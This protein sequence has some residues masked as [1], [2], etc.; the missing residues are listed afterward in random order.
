MKVVLLIAGIGHRLG[1]KTKTIPKSLLEINNKPILFHIVDRIVDNG[2]KDFVVV[3]GYKKEKIINA[4][5]KKY[6]HLNFQFVINEIYDKTNTMYSLSLTKKYINNGII[7]AHG[8]VIVNKN[9]LNDLLDPKNKNAAIVE[10][11]KESMQAFGS[12]GIITKISKKKDAIGKALGIYKF[13]QETVLEI[14]N[15]AEKIIKTGSINVFQSEAINP[16][17]MKHRMDLVSTR[18]RSWVEVDDEN[19]LIKAERILKKIEDE[20]G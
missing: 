1:E 16:V 4:L 12:G 10:P 15:E 6:P 18:G 13:S 7:Y 11:S 14:F 9:I 8:D 17:I 20:E 5:K 2:I 3:V 19:D